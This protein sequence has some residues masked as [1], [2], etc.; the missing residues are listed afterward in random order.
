MARKGKDTDVTVTVKTEDEWNNLIES[1]V[2]PHFTSYNQ[3]IIKGLASH[4]KAKITFTF[5]FSI[6]NALESIWQC[7]NKGMKSES[8]F[9]FAMAS[10]PLQRILTFKKNTVAIYSATTDHCMFL[11]NVT[12]HIYS[13]HQPFKTLIVPGHKRPGATVTLN[14]ML[15]KQKE[16]YLE[17]Y[18]DI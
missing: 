5:H 4:C 9:S 1:K 11:K 7:W 8:G 16:R 10:Q 2:P 14:V 13:W 12:G 17:K 6:I 18:L 15:Q 3:G